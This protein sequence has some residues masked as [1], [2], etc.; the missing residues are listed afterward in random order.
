VAFVVADDRYLAEDAVG[1]IEVVIEPLPIVIASV[2]GRRS[3]RIH[4]DAPEQRRRACSDR[5]RSRTGLEEAPHA[6]A[7]DLSKR[8]G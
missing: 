8:R 6:A 1:L 7:E 2:A 3:P 4:D 5:R